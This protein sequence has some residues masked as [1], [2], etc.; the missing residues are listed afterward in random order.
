M[1][2]PLACRLTRVLQTEIFHDVL[3]ESAVYMA[4]CAS[5]SAETRV[6]A[7]HALACTIEQAEASFQNA[8]G[9]PQVRRRHP[10]RGRDDG[11]DAR[12][13][14]ACGSHLQHQI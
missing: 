13:V 5:R 14:F 9:D 12:G 2:G 11:R 3:Q 10:K 6:R 4:A 1:G 7:V 8:V